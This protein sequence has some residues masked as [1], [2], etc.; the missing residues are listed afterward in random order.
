MDDRI[1]AA[2]VASLPRPGHAFYMPRALEVAPKMLGLILVHETAEGI[3]AGRIT[4][5]EAYEGPEDRACHAYGGRRTA[6]TEIMFGEPGFA[7]VYFT[8][9]M[10]WMFN[11]V[12]G[13]EGTPHAVLIR[14]IEPVTGIDLMT[15]RRGGVMPLAEGPGRLTQAM[16]ITGP[17]NGKDL[18][19]SNLYVAL[20][21][22]G[23]DAPVAFR[24]TKRIGVDNSGEARDYL[25]RF[26]EDR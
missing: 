2:K 4:E 18:T 17:D 23:M 1:D 14:S 22:S 26:V 6:R 20:P 11:A 24:I 3:A 8:Y 7:F 9:G 21:P 15:A 13:P 5:T 19:A 16:G 12:A 25:W 10:H